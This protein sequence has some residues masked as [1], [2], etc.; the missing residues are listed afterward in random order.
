MTLPLL[1]FSERQVQLSIEN[2]VI[3]EFDLTKIAD[4]FESATVSELAWESAIMQIED[5]ISPLKNRLSHYSSCLVRGVAVELPS[6]NDKLGDFW[7]RDLLEQAFGVLSGVRSWRELPDL[8]FDAKTRA[9]LLFLREW[10]HHLDFER[11]YLDKY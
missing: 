10:G 2:Q 8:S 1:K 5:A 4:L 6:Q 9:M 7:D 3:F 11:I